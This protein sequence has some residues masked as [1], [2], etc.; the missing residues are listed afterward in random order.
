[1]LTGIRESLVKFF[2]L[3]QCE[4][5]ADLVEYALVLLLVAVGIVAALQGYATKL[6]AYYNAISASTGW[7]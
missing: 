4:E 6:I 7:N 3:A 2:A 1:M 5:G